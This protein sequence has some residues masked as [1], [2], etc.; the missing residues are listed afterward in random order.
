M[1]QYGVI[2]TGGTEITSDEIIGSGE[3]IADQLSG[4]NDSSGEGATDT[5]GD[6]TTNEPTDETTSTDE[7]GE[8]I[9][10]TEETEFPGMPAN[11][12][13]GSDQETTPP[14]TYVSTKTREELLTIGNLL[15]NRSQKLSTLAT[16]QQNSSAKLTAVSIYQDAVKLLQ[17]LEN[18][19]NIDTLGKIEHD[20]NMVVQRFISLAQRM[21]GSTQ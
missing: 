5:S 6:T 3:S 15:V 9:I 21:N 2:P 12:T 16:T 19:A 4:T 11:E 17:V 8:V 10:P 7:G 1:Q 13:I 14:E 20:M 18:D